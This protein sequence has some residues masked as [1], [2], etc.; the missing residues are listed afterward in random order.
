MHRI[1]ITLAGAVLTT[2]T[3][4]ASEQTDVMATVNQLVAAFNKGDTKSL[5]DVCTDQMCIIDEFPP[6][7]WHGAGTGLQP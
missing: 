3:L 4:V 2:A 5:L 7:E 1:M 6:H